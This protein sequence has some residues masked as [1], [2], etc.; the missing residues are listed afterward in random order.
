MARPFALPLLAV[1]LLTATAAAAQTSGPPADEAGARDLG[2]VLQ[3]GATEWMVGGGVGMGVGRRV[4]AENSSYV[5][6]SFSWGRV[7]TRPAGWGFLRGRFEW[8][9]E[10]TPLFAQYAPG[11][12]RGL[13]VSP[14]VWR[15]S[16]DRRGPVAGFVEVAGGGLWT[17]HALP[18]GTVAGN[19]TAHGGAG[20]RILTGR[21]RGVVLAYRLDHISNGNRADR[22]PGINAHVVYVGWNVIAVH[23]SQ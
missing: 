22:N 17:N 3:S 11:A 4:D 5:F 21:R 23:S 15:W 8:A 13:G 18:A 9:F 12:T 20:L 7:L 16:F 19:F 1:F 10:V 6:Q 2:S 14:L